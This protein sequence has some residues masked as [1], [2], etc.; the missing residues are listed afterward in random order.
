MK[1]KELVCGNVALSEAAIRAGCRYYFG[2]PITPQNEVTS[3]MSLRMDEVGGVFLQAESELA[4]INMVF[5]AALTGAKAMTTSSSPGIS[6]M[7]EGISYL[8]GC[9]LPAVIVNVMRGGPGLG[10]IA[11]S[12]SDYFQAVKGGGHG[13]YRLLVFAPSTVQE[14]ADYTYTAFSKAGEY[15]MQVMILMDGLLGQMMEPVYFPD[16]SASFSY[17]NDWALT[18]CENREPRSIKSLLLEE[19]ALE[20]HN[21]NLQ[22][23]YDKIRKKEVLYDTFLADDA[24]VLLA[25][26]GFCGRLCRKAVEELRKKGIKAGLFRPITLWPFPGEVFAGLSKKP[27]KI[28]CVEMNAGQMVEDIMLYADDKNKVR[29]VGRTGGGVPSVSEIVTAVI[30]A[31]DEKNI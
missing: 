6:L 24:D 22:K 7:Q 26:F 17:R 10:N 12:Q 28:F 3:Y 13:D 21:E 9:E 18:G 5:G 29:F 15:R 20:R 31:R 14:V 1:E 16:M 30:R 8:A 2:Y 25:A 27:A 19:G 23:K 11:P 4:S